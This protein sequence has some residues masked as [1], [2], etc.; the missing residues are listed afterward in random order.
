MVKETNFCIGEDLLQ[1][2]HELFVSTLSSFLHRSKQ[3]SIILL[4]F[5]NNKITTKYCISGF[6][7]GYLSSRM[8][9]VGLVRENLFSR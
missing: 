6:F 8:Y 7:R 1:L 3:C 5:K 4:E 2:Q 9:T